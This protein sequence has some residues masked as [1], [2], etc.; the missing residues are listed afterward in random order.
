MWQ[1]ID[2]KNGSRIYFQS[3]SIIEDAETAIDIEYGALYSIS[4]AVFNK[5]YVHIYKHMPSGGSPIYTGDYVIAKSKFLCQTTA[6]IS[7][8][9]PV[10]TTLA[11][12]HTGQRTSIAI[13]AF[14][15]PKMLVGNTFAANGNTIDNTDWGVFDWTVKK[16]QVMYN[17]L[18]NI[19]NGGVY[20]VYG[21]GLGGETIDIN[22][23]TFNKMPYPIFC[24]DNKPTS[25]THI[26]NNTIDFDGMGTPPPTGMRGITVEE[27]TPASGSNL[28]FV[29]ISHNT[30]YKAPTGIF[31]R[32]LKGDNNNQKASIYIYDNTITHQQSS[33]E[34]GAGINMQNVVQS[35]VV[36]NKISHPT[37]GINWWETAI[38]SSSGSNENGFYCNYLHHIGNGIVFNGYQNTNTVVANN[39][40]ERNHRAFMLNWGDVGPQNTSYPYPHDNEWIDPSYWDITNSKYTTQVIGI[41]TH[42]T[43][44]G[45]RVGP[46]S[47]YYP[48]HNHNTDP[49]PPAFQ[50]PISVIGSSWQYGCVVNGLHANFKTDGS[51]E[52]AELPN[53]MNIIEPPEAQS[54]REANQQWIAK[55]GLY[56]YLTRNSAL[57]EESTA[58]SHFRAENEQSNIGKLQRAIAGFNQTEIGIGQQEAAD[59]NTIQPTNSVE[60]TLKDVLTILY[61]NA[62]DLRTLSEETSEQLREIAKRCPLDDGMGVYM[63]RAALLSVDTLPK[64]YAN[65]C[66]ILPGLEESR[67]KTGVETDATNTWL[68]PNPTSGQLNM[69]VHL[70]EDETA[71]IEVFNL[72]GQKV[73]SQ[74]LNNEIKNVDLGQLTNGIYTIRL[75]VNGNFRYT[76]KLSIVK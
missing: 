33:S 36:D 67:Q 23:N 14:G 7:L 64:D 59:L 66:E 69:D 76:E 52:A 47:V 74:S 41:N 50:I 73:F 39:D 1:G 15:V 30:I 34:Q 13:Q 68:Y 75:L 63:A 37:S 6:T 22:N 35:S 44:F 53:Y 54:D 3:N 65:V 51:E 61:A 32:N 55:Y 49:T 70:S 24:Y 72:V 19:G 16:V 48:A 43:S 2:A 26:K 11:A 71:T 27:I 29:D 20:A 12:P 40:F 28:N 9:T 21:S 17:T 8:P 62:T 56:N 46:P 31:L 57:A 18:R 58:M 60:Q 25:R 4:S 5:N 10:Y 45:V 42:T 38:R